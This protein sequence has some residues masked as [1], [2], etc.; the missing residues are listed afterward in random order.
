MA[1]ANQVIALQNYNDLEHYLRFQTETGRIKFGRR[2]EFADANGKYVIIF[3]S[4]KIYTVLF[5][6]EDKYYDLIDH[7]EY[8]ELS[9]FFQGKR[10][11]W[12]ELNQP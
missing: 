5:Y 10:Q 9:Q 1:F 6:N 7:R 4:D 12:V 2:E 8:L 11:C 3:D